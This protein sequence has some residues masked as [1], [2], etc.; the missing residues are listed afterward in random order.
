M[1][2]VPIVNNKL[3]VYAD[4]PSRRHSTSCQPN[5][6]LLSVV[7]KH[8]CCSLSSSPKSKSSPNSS[9]VSS[10]LNALFKKKVKLA[11]Q[12][13]EAELAYEA[14]PTI[15]GVERSKCIEIPRPI[16]KTSSHPGSQVSTCESDESDE[17]EFSPRS[18]NR[19]PRLRSVSINEVVEVL[20]MDDNTKFCTV[21][22][23]RPNN[24]MLPLA[25]R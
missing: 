17:S 5:R 4:R 22:V 19:S 20:R 1:S 2:F 15:P 6:S 24:A 12:T 9:P 13:E 18:E 11:L 7:E 21:L 3:N 16:L 14:L 10:L 25:S 23:D 8:R